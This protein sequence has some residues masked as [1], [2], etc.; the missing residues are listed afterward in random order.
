M[1]W[2]PLV[3]SLSAGFAALLTGILARRATRR[4]LDKNRAEVHQMTAA[5]QVGTMMGA[6]STG[7]PPGAVRPEQQLLEALE[8]RSEARFKIQSAH[9]SN[10]L[11]QST[12][13]F[14]LSIAVG[15]V[16]FILIVT[17]VGLAMA[18]ILEVATLTGLGGLLAEGAAA[19]IFNQSN[20]AKS[21]AQANLAAIAQAAERDDNRKMALILASKVEDASLRDIT[22]ADL[23]RLYLSLL[24]TSGGSTPA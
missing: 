8:K 9:Y 14:F 17:G 4:E 6:V 13:Y 1:D 11:S 7:V 19:L 10:A 24:G 16:G 21:D 12:I 22:N 5:Q 3:A 18:K 2:I 23:A 15:V 20:R